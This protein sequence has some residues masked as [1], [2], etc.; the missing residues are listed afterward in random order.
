MAGGAWMSLVVTFSDDR[1]AH[2]CNS[3][4]ATDQAWGPA[5]RDV[6]ESL[7]VL[8]SSPALDAYANH[9]NVAHEGDLTVYKGRLVDVLLELAPADGPKPGVHMKSIDIRDRGRSTT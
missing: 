5:A 8:A 6:R 7:C 9:P 1:I 2:R 4:V 3:A